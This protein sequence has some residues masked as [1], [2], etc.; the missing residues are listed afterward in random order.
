MLTQD[1]FNPHILTI[2]RLSNL[3]T[4]PLE[5]LWQNRIPRGK[6]TLLAG[7]PGSGKTALT[8]DLAARLSRGSPMPPLPPTIDGSHSTDPSPLTTDH[9]PPTTLL[10][11]PDDN[12]Q[13]TLRPT[14]ERLNA[15]LDLIHILPDFHSLIPPKPHLHD[16]PDLPTPLQQLDAAC[17]AIPNLAL[18]VIDPITYYLGL[19]DRNLPTPKAQGSDPWAPRSI[20]RALAH[21]AEKHHLAILLTSRLAKA[22]NP[23]SLHRI[24]GGVGSLAT[25]STA[26]SVLLLTPAPQSP[27]STTARSNG[28]SSTP[29]P[30]PQQPPS[31]ILN[32]PLPNSEFPLPT[33][34]LLTL[35]SNLTA[36]PPPL[37][38]TL[39]DT[40]T[41]SPNP[42]TP[43]E[44]AALEPP[45]RRKLDLPCEAAARLLRSLLKHGPLPASEIAKSAAANFIAGSTLSR[46]KAS[47][48]ALSLKQ[49]GPHGRWYWKLCDDPRN[50]PE[51]PSSDA[52]LSEILTFLENRDNLSEITELFTEDHDN[53]SGNP[54]KSPQL[55]N[56]HPT[57]SPPPT[58]K[59]PSPSAPSPKRNA[60]EPPEK[61]HIAPGLP[62]VTAH[63][64]KDERSKMDALPPRPNAIARPE[65]AISPAATQNSPHHYGKLAAL[66]REPL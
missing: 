15:N 17:S 66:N 51:P 55:I 8:L 2:R 1:S 23:T 7:D 25:T 21:L 18:L 61:L 38:F 65:P 27:P 26:R 19:T 6:I 47:L 62:G 16:D 49:P 4:K 60:P 57:P 54:P 40:I 34:L 43:A 30:L 31:P 48:G 56:D 35:K 50:P 45:D 36:P 32:S 58:A 59:K 29:A 10:L 13:D 5:W 11:S 20:L 63:T 24:L 64:S 12:A 28:L 37:A 52:D 39:A 42:L 14:L 3:P 41:W 9:R 46:A 33:H 53:L 22:A 44:V